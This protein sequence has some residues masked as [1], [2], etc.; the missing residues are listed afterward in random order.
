MTTGTGSSTP[1]RSRTA[2]RS[3]SVVCGVMRSTIVVTKATCSPIQAARPGST[4]A[5]SSPTTR[6]A[7]APLSGTLSQ[8]TT[9]RPGRSCARRT[10]SPSA[11]LP[12]AVTTSASVPCAREGGDVGRDLRVPGVQA[13]VGGAPVA[14]LGDGGGHQR[15]LGA[16]EAAPPVVE[17]GRDRRD[18]RNDLG[19]VAVGGAHE[20][21]VEPV[22]RG[23]VA[24]DHAAA[25]GEGGDA[26]LGGVRGVLGVP[27][28]VGAEEVAGAEVRDPH[29]GGGAAR[30]RSRQ[31]WSQLERHLRVD[32][33]EVVRRREGLVLVEAVGGDQLGEVAAVQPA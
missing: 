4:A 13:A 23:E 11:S 12:G 26:P 8:G 17:L 15:E 30:A 27:G 25:S 33:H 1:S 5:A 31:S 21:R 24:G 7:I 9:A 32:G 16:G 3:S 22:L 29:R 14:R 20:Q 19:P 28:L 18:R 6:A 10:A 2:A